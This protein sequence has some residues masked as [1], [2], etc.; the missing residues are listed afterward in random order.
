MIRPA[1][2]LA[3]LLVLG[4]TAG[5]QEDGASPDIAEDLAGAWQIVPVDG[6]PACRVTLGI[7]PMPGGWKAEP[8]AQCAAIAPAAA[9]TV[10]WTFRDGLR[11]LDAKGVA[12]MQFEEDETALLSSPSVA[13]PAFY[14]VPAIPGYGRLRQPR[15]WEGAWQFT[16][17]G[18][19]PCVLLFGPPAKAD[20][21]HDGGSVVVRH[22]RSMALKRMDRWYLEGMDVMLAGSG[23]AQMVFTPDGADTHRSDDGRWRLSPWSASPTLK[24]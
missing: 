12:V 2:L 9:T 7:A 3:G 19:K 1:G 6:S 4:S 11:L 16:A 13:A 24:R 10:A 23:D 8:G 22:C 15:E 5:A 14:L 20:G 21:Q 18:Q 17:R